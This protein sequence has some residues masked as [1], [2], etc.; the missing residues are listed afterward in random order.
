[1]TC[2]EKGRDFFKVNRFVSTQLKHTVYI[3]RL[4]SG[5]EVVKYSEQSSLPHTGAWRLHIGYKLNDQGSEEVVFASSG[6]AV[7]LM[8]QW[9]SRALFRS[10]RTNT[11][12]EQ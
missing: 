12:C 11:V 4:F 3:L 1:M 5:D 7:V 8:S 9:E 6:Q 2:P 10:P